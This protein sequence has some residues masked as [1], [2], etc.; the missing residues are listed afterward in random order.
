MNVLAVTILVS[1]AFAVFFVLM[2][3][4]Q[5]GGRSGGAGG[6]RD[7]LLPLDDDDE[8]NP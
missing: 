3:L 6:E 7:A 8:E 2:F 5:R 4:S 1:V